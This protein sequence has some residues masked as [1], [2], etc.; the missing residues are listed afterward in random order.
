MFNYDW[1]EKENY[2]FYSGISLLGS[3]AG[4]PTFGLPIGLNIYPFENKSFG[5]LMEFAPDLPFGEGNG[6]YFTGSWGIRYR[7]NKKE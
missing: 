4:G 6:G 3:T 5:F 2:E 7:F 1:I